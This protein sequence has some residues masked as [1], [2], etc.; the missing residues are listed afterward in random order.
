MKSPISAEN[1]AFR[2]AAPSL[3]SSGRATIR[4][5]AYALLTLAAIPFQMLAVLLRIGFLARG[6]PY[7]Y[8]RLVCLILG[9]KIE[10]RGERSTDAPTL[11]VGNHVSYLDIE[12][13]GSNIPASFV[14]K[15]EVATWPFFNVLAKLQ[16]TVFVERSTRATRESRDSLIGRL[17]SGDSLI[18][19]PEGTSSD[20]TRVLPF[21]SALFAAA[22]VTPGGKPLRVQP[23]TVA[24]TRLDGI[25]LG[26]YWRPYFTWYGDME[27]AVHLWN[28]CKLGECSVV[29]QFH[30]PVDITMFGDRKKLSDHCF[31]VVSR[32]LQAINRG[33]PAQPSPAKA[34]E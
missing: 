11:Y 4:L 12:T 13:L 3:G 29:I 20:G 6:I 32:S 21:R 27:L 18:L 8:H 16:R 2:E 14:A 10:V 7:Y 26:R 28:V 19:F 23:F 15:Q 17:E 1:R 22:Q 33:E 31:R 5:L 24:Y 30:D 34:A 25:P 9:L